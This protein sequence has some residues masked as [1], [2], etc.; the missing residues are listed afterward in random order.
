MSSKK[1]SWDSKSALRKLSSGLSVT[2]GVTPIHVHKT[3]TGDHNPK[4]DAYRS[5]SNCGKHINYHK[6][7]T[8][9]KSKL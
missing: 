3:I 7:E 4:T 8:C 5:C 9:P 6:G 1:F 2:V